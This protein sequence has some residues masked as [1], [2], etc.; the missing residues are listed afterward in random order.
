M[1]ADELRR[2]QAVFDA[3]IELPPDQRAEFLDRTC[4][5]DA[6]TRAAVERLLR[7]DDAVHGGTFISAAVDEAAKE[8]ASA[9][10]APAQTV[11]AYRLLHELGRGGMGTVWLAE[12]ADEAY[13]ARVAIKFVRGG[14][15]HPELERRFRAERQ[16]LADVR[17]PNIARLLDGGDAPDG[18]PYL[19]MEYV[20]GEPITDYATR[21]A[22]SIG[23]RLRIFRLACEAV[24]H[25]HNSLVVHRDIKPS[26]ILVQADGVPKLLDFGIARP[27]APGV[28]QET[29]AAVRL[30]TPSYASPEQVR[31]D[32]LTVATDVYSL[33][34]L[35]YELLTGTHPFAADGTSSAE[36]QRRVLE[37]EPRAPSDVARRR[38]ANLPPG[39]GARELAGDLDN[40]VAKALRKEP[41]RRY[42][43]VLELSEDVERHLTGR[44]VVARR[45][46][47]AY[48][49]RKFV[50]R[51]RAG[52]AATTVAAALFAGGGAL[53][54]VQLSRERDVANRE[55]ASAE[56]VTAF[57]TDIFRSAD[58]SHALGDTITA[59]QLLAGARQ[60]LD[61][62]LTGQPRVRARLLGT[63]GE[64][65]LGLGRYAQADSLLTE[66][67]R[68]MERTEGPATPRVAALLESRELSQVG[69]ERWDDA[70]RSGRRAVVIR[71]SAGDTAALAKSLRL[72]AG[73]YVS[74]HDFPSAGPLFTRALALL[75]ADVSADTVPWAATLNAYGNLLMFEAHYDSALAV[76]RRALAIRRAALDPRDPLIAESLRNLATVHDKLGQRDSARVLDEQALAIYLHAYGPD[77]PDVVSLEGN[78]GDVLSEAGLKDSAIALHMRVLASDQRT[79]GPVNQRVARALMSIGNDYGRAGDG[80]SAVVWLRRSLA[81]SEKVLPP[82]NQNLA[83]PL[84]NLAAALEMI[85]HYADALPLNRR[86]LAIEEKATGP[87]HPQVGMALSEIGEDL[88]HMGRDGDAEPYFRRAIRTMDATV[89]PSDPLTC[90]PVEDLADL[91][92]RHGRY[93]EAVQLYGRELPLA[94]GPRYSHDDPALAVF[95][96]KYARALRHVGDTS[97]A[98]GLEAKARALRLAAA[99]AR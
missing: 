34:V 41:E 86:A 94:D 23:D 80:A 85:G 48:R 36:V 58:P 70:I 88:M 77:H 28:G 71:E 63:L 2:V 95:Y 44:P 56:Q 27:L 16:I 90:Y 5:S 43:S 4:A 22:L 19:V 21:H 17:H 15:A 59:R 89:G 81:L 87:N 96:E 98:R 13:R 25:A 12:R 37:V 84:A 10:V 53:H 67:A 14:F 93:A 66:G 40:I 73:A 39:A 54:I 55:R 99:P 49:L 72:L 9:P 74:K 1:N 42:G 30:M 83:Y 8:F 82:D 38:G 65:Y 7:A 33:G 18:S 51:H 79:F 68:L 60:R 57:L 64:V 78:L 32:R 50:G 62:A 69:L 61:S 31:G 26:N 29:T 3:A 91:D 20:D 47:T 46:T 11:G 97:T 52:V 35:L 92:V 24:Q 76:H 6:A 45:T 75:Q